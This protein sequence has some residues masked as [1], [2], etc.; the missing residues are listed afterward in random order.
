M[1]NASHYLATETLPN[2][3]RLLI[4]ATEPHDDLAGAVQRQ[5]SPKSF[6]Y[7]FLKPK[8]YLTDEEIAP[9]MNCD[10]VRQVALIG[11]VRQNIRMAIVAGAR[12]WITRPDEAEIAFMVADEYQKQG[13]GT[14]M[15]NHLC[16]IARQAGLKRFYA[17]ATPD[18]E[19]A[20]HLLKKLGFRC[21]IRS[22]P[23]QRMMH[24]TVHFTGAAP[25]EGSQTD[26][27]TGL[28]SNS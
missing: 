21:D 14:A 18:N 23:A 16:S 17:L 11:L 26:K 20:M 1:L 25:S 10:F 19:G 8:H 12:Y 5:A 7:R 6:F 3:L 13:I 27:E 2:G 9:L 28:Q 4:R 22:D 24:V 15:L